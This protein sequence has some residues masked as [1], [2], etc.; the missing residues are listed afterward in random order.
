M[1]PADILLR[2]AA[3]FG[4]FVACGL[5][6][7]DEAE[8]ALLHAAVRITDSPDGLLALE[9]AVSAAL[10]D[11]TLSH[12][13]AI[14]ARVRAAIAP[15]IACRACKAAILAQAR[16]ANNAQDRLDALPDAAVSDIVKTELDAALTRLREQR[17]RA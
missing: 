11:A 2:S 9:S 7:H 5:L 12:Q 8:S 4:K 15:L 14:V 13:L 3:E 6:S 16:Y 1:T 10:S 17:R